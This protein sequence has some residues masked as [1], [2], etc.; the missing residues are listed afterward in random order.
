MTHRPANFINMNTPAHIIVAIAALA[1][2]DASK[3]NFAIAAG[4]IAPDF[5]IFVF[6][7]WTQLFTNLTMEQIWREA[8]WTEPWQTFGAIS[9]SVPLALIILAFGIWQKREHITVFALAMLIHAG[10]DFPLHNDDAHRHFW[11]LTDWRFF[12]PVSYWDVNHHGRF[13]T[14]IEAIMSFIACFIIWQRFPAR[15][16]RIVVGLMVALQ[17]A[18][19]SFIFF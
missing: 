14:I 7:A 1:R 6:F 9:N 17:L 13:G 3:R 8:Y 12:S 18:T 10:L 16:V 4:A 11:P 2:K 19:I 15:W 5:S